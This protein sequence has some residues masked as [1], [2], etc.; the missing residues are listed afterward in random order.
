MNEG[1]R[2][3]RAI[4]DR[5]GVLASMGAAVA[6][7]WAADSVPA[8]DNAAD[9]VADRTSSIRIK[10]LKAVICRDRVFVRI[11]RLG[12]LRHDVFQRRFF[13]RFGGQGMFVVVVDTILLWR[14]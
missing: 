10:A 13:L 14:H 6:G 11:R 4:S 3:N 7:V 8:A 9:A 12:G 1:A 5:R 2:T